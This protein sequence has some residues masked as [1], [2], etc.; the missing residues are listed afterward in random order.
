MFEGG[1][2][3]ADT[4]LDMANVHF[5]QLGYVMIMLGSLAEGLS[6]PFPSI[7]LMI[8][9]GTAVAHGRMSFS[10][11]VLIAS[12]A[13]T[14]GALIPYTIGFH[15][16]RL[17]KYPWCARFAE[18]PPF[19][20]VNELFTKHGPKIVALSRPFLIGNCVSYVAGL[21]HMAPIKFVAYT[22]AGILPWAVAATTIGLLFG[23]NL[24]KA[25]DLFQ[26]YTTAFA[27]VLLAAIAAMYCYKKHRKKIE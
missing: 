6:L 23:A 4:L 21:T 8:M 14:A 24:D 25:V 7:V 17:K 20:R 22:F 18:T 15:L 11:V 19:W 27:V 9:A 10:V 16:P 12:L 26:G 5:A 2:R 3:V 1:V 13:Y